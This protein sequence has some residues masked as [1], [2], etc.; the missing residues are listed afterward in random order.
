MRQQ[1]WFAVVV[2]VIAVIPGFFVGGLVKAV[3]YVFGGWAENSDFLYLHALFGLDGP[4]ALYNF[5]FA[6]AIPDTFQ[7]GVG[8]FVAVWIT[9]KAARGANYALA[10]T[11]TGALYTGFVACLIL[12]I[13][14]HLGITSEM[15][16]S[17]CQCVGLWI[18]LG[19]TAAAFP[20]PASRSN[21]AYP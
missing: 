14:M 4:G 2:C 20:V 16:L 21:A 13:F 9:E 17:I 1:T 11:I 5:I 12:V 3:M 19:G 18:G 6:H 10:A 7:G 15:L 8:G